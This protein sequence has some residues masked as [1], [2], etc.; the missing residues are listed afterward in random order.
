M[1][2]C[3]LSHLISRGCCCYLVG[4]E[5]PINKPAD[6]IENDASLSVTALIV[7]LALVFTLYFAGRAAVPLLPDHVYHALAALPSANDS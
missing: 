7:V 4:M 1:S 2:P 5:H 6:A 3:G